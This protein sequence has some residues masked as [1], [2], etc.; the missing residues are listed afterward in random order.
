MTPR[1][2]FHRIAPNH[3]DDGRAESRA[4]TLS[5]AVSH[6]SQ[7]GSVTSQNVEV[8]HIKAISR[9]V[10]LNSFWRAIIAKNSKTVTVTTNLGATLS[11]GCGQLQSTN[12]GCC[13]NVTDAGIS[14]LSHGCSQ[15]Q[16]LFLSS[17]NK[18]TDAG[19]TA[20]S[21]GCGQLQIIDISRCDK[22][23]DA[24]VSA[25]GLTMTALSR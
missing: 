11:H 4:V 12:L 20:L 22:M 1:S 17:C 13:N 21:H 7:Y 8:N 19:I 2:H 10:P 9:N 5:P 16:S 24:V 3:F 14:A 25:L 15:Q 6:H 23:T 18:V